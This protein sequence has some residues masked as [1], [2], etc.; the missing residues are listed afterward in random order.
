SSVTLSAVAAAAQILGY[1]CEA[2]LSITRT[3]LA[4]GGHFAPEERVFPSPC[5]DEWALSALRELR[6]SQPGWNKQALL[7]NFFFKRAPGSSTP[8]CKRT[9]QQ[10]PLSVETRPRLS[11]S[12][13]LH[14]LRGEGSLYRF[15][16]RSDANQRSPAAPSVLLAFTA[17]ALDTPSLMG[18]HSAPTPPVCPTGEPWWPGPVIII[19]ACCTTPVFLFLVFIICYKAIKRKPLRKEENGTSQAEYAM[20]SSQNNK[21]VDTNN[22]VV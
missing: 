8:A 15:P 20:T 3:R 19:A 16:Q 9:C 11:P 4:G 1:V 21:E 12:P 18:L 6:A 2:G 22:A 13:R 5:S 7:A 17:A 10:R 14:R